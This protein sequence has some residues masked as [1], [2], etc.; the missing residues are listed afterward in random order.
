[1]RAIHRQNNSYLVVDKLSCF[2]ISVR[3]FFV[4]FF[5]EASLDG[6]LHTCNLT[7]EKRC[8]SRVAIL[9]RNENIL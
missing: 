5:P 9:K 3:I 8:V 1:M 4:L 7:M 6:Q 2:D